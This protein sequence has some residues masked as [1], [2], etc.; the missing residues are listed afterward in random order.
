MCD[1]IVATLGL[2]LTWDVKQQNQPTN[3]HWDFRVVRAIIYLKTIVEV[4]G[5]T[6]MYT[7]L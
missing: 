3:Q 6:N 7:H 5:K 1:S 2:L 4:Y